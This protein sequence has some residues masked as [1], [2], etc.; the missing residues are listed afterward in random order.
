MRPIYPF[1][2][3]D[4][5]LTV[6][7]ENLW[8]CSCGLADHDW[9]GRVVLLHRGVRACEERSVGFMESANVLNCLRAAAARIQLHPG[10]NGCS[11]KQRSWDGGN[12]TS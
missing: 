8:L 12:R 7:G 3:A 4:V 11:E 2:M 1:S 10:R 6:A 5:V 9:R